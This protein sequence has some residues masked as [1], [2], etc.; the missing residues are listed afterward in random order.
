MFDF[1][2]LT[3]YCTTRKDGTGFQL[4]RRTE[5]K[6]MRAKL[7]EITET[8]RRDRHRPI[9]EQGGWLGAV[10]RGY[11]AYFA[12]P[13]GHRM[14]SAFRAHVWRTMVPQSATTQPAASDDL[15]TDE[16]TDRTLLAT[17]PRAAPVAGPEVSRQVLKVG[18]ECLNWACS[19]LCGGRS[20]MSVPTAI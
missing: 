13:T 20:A 5:R 7:N 6:R 3:H 16:P 15:G 19:D 10:V 9:D 12:V 1:L 14:L 8:L 17:R 4:G 18:A 2:G 11:F